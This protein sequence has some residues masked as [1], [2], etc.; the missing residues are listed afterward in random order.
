MVFRRL[1]S[2]VQEGLHIRKHV[3]RSQL[4]TFSLAME[5][6]SNN[7]SAEPWMFEFVH[8]SNT[9]FHSS[10]YRPY[11][12]PPVLPHFAEGGESPYGAQYL[13]CGLLSCKVTFNRLTLRSEALA[14]RAC[15]SLFLG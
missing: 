4:C 12:Y 13:E 9:P 15:T 10:Q 2:R 14:R 11:V 8:S 6:N 1:R 3:L 7:Q 5:S